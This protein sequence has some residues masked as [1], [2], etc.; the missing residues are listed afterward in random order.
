MNTLDRFIAGSPDVL[1]LYQLI[2]TNLASRICW[3]WATSEG[4]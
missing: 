3:Q 1:A 4:L 2:P